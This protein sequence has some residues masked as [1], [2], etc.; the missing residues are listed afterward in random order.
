MRNFL[1][2]TTLLG[3]L[4]VGCSEDKVVDCETTSDIQLKNITISS[5]DV[6]YTALESGDQIVK[7]SEDPEIE[8]IHTVSGEKSVCVKSGEA[9]IIR[10]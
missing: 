8:I 5:C 2:F 6:N 7:I 1:L 3:F 4:F 9:K 10:E